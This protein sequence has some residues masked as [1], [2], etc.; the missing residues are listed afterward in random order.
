[1]NVITSPVYIACTLSLFVVLSGLL[2]WKHR[3]G[4]AQRRIRRGLK[5]Y[6]TGGSQVLS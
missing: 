4:H 1:M 3:K 2:L 6:T 5:V